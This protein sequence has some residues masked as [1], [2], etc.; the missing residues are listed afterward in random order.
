MRVM[1]RFSPLILVLALGASACGLGTGAIRA[2]LVD[3]LVEEAELSDAEAN[4]VA[5][6]LYATPGLT[7]ADINSFSTIGQMDPGDDRA[8]KFALYEAAVDTAV[9]TCVR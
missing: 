8:G 7:E 6:A 3:I 1:R 4:C 5:N 2:A 9:R